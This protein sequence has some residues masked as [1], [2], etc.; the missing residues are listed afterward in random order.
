MKPNDAA[1]PGRPLVAILRGIDPSEAVPIAAVLV[2]AGITWIEVPLNSPAP[3][4]SIRAIVQSQPDAMIGAGTVLTPEDVANV[5][6]AGGRLI[7]SPDCDRKVVEAARML[8]MLS[9]PGVLTATECLK[10][11]KLGAT[12]LKVFPAFQMGIEGLRAVRAVLPPETRLYMVGGVGPDDFAEWVA[13]G[14]S[15]FGLGSS[16][17]K[18]GDSAEDVAA[19]AREAV[20]A[21]DAAQA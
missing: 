13:T 2:E 8:R 6:N 9:F 10:A 14:A 19:R 3:Y 1:L 15:G 12:G 21:W 11:I 4:D 17:Y 16:L 18:P 7:V 20:A 5:H